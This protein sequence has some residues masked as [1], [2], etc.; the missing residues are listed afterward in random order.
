MNQV[1]VCILRKNLQI[2]KI[3]ANN[4]ISFVSRAVKNIKIGKNHS[5]LLQFAV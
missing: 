1:E 4:I 2:L 5:N 3:N